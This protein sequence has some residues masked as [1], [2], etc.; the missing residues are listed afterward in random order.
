MLV[1]EGMFSAEGR[2]LGIFPAQLGSNLTYQVTYI[3][4]CLKVR[5]Y[6]NSYYYRHIL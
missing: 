2:D 1:R 6:F 5:T 4:L 3:F